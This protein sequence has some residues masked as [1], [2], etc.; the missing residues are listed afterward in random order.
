MKTRNF[1]IG[2]FALLTMLSFSSCENSLLDQE[3]K[4]FGIL[5]ENFKV[6]I[7]SS[8]SNN[9]KS[10]ELKSTTSD[11]LNGN[12]IYWY[13][14]AYIAVGEGAA[15]IV[16]AI[17]WSIRFY[18]IEDVITLT[19]TSNDD[20][21]VKNLDVIADVEFEGHQWEYQLTITDAESEGNEDGGIGMQVFWSKNPIEGI[22]IIK[23][24]NLDRTEHSDSPNAIGRIEYSERITDKYDAT[25][26]VEMAGLP[27]VNTFGV[28]SM[29]MFVGRRGD[30]VDVIGNSSHPKARFN[31]YDETV[32]YNWAFVASGNDEQ[33]IAVAEV[34][35]PY[36][37]Q[38]LTSREA[39]LEDYSIKSVLTREMTNFVVAAWAKAGITLVPEEIENYVAPYLANADA[40]GYFNSNGFVKGGTAPGNQYNEFEDRIELLTPYNPAEIANLSISFKY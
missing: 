20:N 34:G 28:G 12:A 30:V 25:M 1:I 19:Y 3:E 29:K 38:N 4:E 36:G 13:L 39:I 14:N 37:S 40:P 24:Y 17:I 32:G 33:N 8:L 15:D 23:P 35:L 22:A 10:A 11:S 2:M 16:E 26:I 27:V 6:D 18:N 21:R 5:P 31:I 9:L 7:P